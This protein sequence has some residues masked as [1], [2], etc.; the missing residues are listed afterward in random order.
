MLA[1]R[2]WS[3]AL[4]IGVL[5]LTSCASEPASQRDRVDPAASESNV[6]RSDAPESA[7]AADP[8]PPESVR[9]ADRCSFDVPGR[10]FTIPGPDA[11]TWLAAAELGAGPDVAVFLH[12][13]GGAGLC[14]WL[15]Y[16]EWAT[17]HGVRAVL[18][19]GCYYGDTVCSDPVSDNPRAWIG[20]AV[21]WAREHGARRVTLVGASM[22]GAL[23]TGAGQEAGADAIVNLSSPP[24][25][26][27]VPRVLKAARKIRVPF[28]VAGSDADED[29]STSVLRR[30]V[31]L[32]PAP[33]TRYV[34]TPDGHGWSMVTS[35]GFSN[36]PSDTR[37]SPLGRVL[38]RW[39]SG[40]VG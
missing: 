12:Q 36:T 27:D 13:T 21:D 29:I 3:L 10:T 24:A 20:S 19:D 28:L 31:R 5:A 2:G 32:S 14:G 26:P 25:W 7:T 38:L 35:S 39:I 4:L 33:V 16:A 18:V 34:A 15:P 40:N 8:A 17:R 6:P 9:L 23:A 30:A 22:G 1:A 11:T 37:P